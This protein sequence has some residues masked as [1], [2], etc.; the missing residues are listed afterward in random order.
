MVFFTICIVQWKYATRI[1]FSQSC[2]YYNYDYSVAADLGY[3]AVMADPSL[4][5]GDNTTIACSKRFFDD[6]YHT[7]VTEVLINS[8]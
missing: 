7:V 5:P 3:E 6:G 1:I 8:Y 2:V 4:V